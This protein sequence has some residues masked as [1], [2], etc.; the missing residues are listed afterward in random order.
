MF[1]SLLDPSIIM[2]KSK[3]L[4]SYFFVTLDFLS[5]KNYVNLASKSNK[6]KKMYYKNKFFAGI[7]K[8]NDEN[9][10]IRIH[11][12][13]AR[14]RIRIHP[15]MSWIRNTACN[16]QRLNVNVP[17]CTYGMRPVKIS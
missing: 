17:T 12:S 14:I 16:V 8:V 5:L 4:D 11:L 10:R 6:Q 9:S 7:L 3:N 13:E 2:Q 1:L 15:K